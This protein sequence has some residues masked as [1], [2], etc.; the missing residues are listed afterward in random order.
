[1][2]SEG[3]QSYIYTCIQAIKFLKQP[4][5]HVKG[6]QVIILLCTVLFNKTLYPD[7]ENTLQDISPKFI[8]RNSAKQLDHET[9]TEHEPDFDTYYVTT[10]DEL[11]SL[12]F[13]F[14]LH[15]MKTAGRTRRSMVPNVV[16][17]T[18]GTREMLG[19]CCPFRGPDVGDTQ[20]DVQ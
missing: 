8:S 1:M 16:T 20:S 14:L 11:T 3:I 6:F 17:T 2:N 13:S 10:L 5:L 18:T 19:K 9:Q 4:V 15:R 12:S 7:T